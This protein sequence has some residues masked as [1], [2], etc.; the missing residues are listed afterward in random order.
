MNVHIFSLQGLRKQN[1][2]T[3]IAVING[4]GKNPKIK[5]INLYAV[6]DG[7][8]G[9]Q[10]SE[11]LKNSVPKYFL[12]KK[13]SYPLNKEYV[14]NVFNVLQ[15]ELKTKPFSKSV[16]STALIVAHYKNPNDPDSSYLNI[17]N[18]GDSRCILC[19]SNF[20]MPL[21]K[22]H[23]PNWPEEYCRISE[24]GGK[25]EFDQRDW[26]IKDLSVSRAFG[27]LDA[28]PFVTHL[29]DLFKYKLDKSDKFI[30]IC[31]DGMLETLTNEVAVN[32]VLLNCYSKDTRT[33]INKDINIA[34]RLAEF[35]LT[36]G[37]GDNISIIVVF[38]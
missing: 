35:A 16:G 27:D 9:L 12:N 13:V 30:I 23:K 18:T 38:F 6:F 10:V 4:D 26:R 8:G 5:D 32:F 28:T 34:Q 37:S 17:L 31:C 36:K 22:D 7:H 33:R 29:P 25:I 3:H 24:L 1:E 15:N 14:V 19:R 21:T 20:A 2:D 11:F